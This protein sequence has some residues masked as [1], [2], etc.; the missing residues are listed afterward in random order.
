MYLKHLMKE[1]LAYYIP[2]V[3]TPIAWLIVR[4]AK[5]YPE[6]VREELLHPN[7]I[8]LF[9]VWQEFLKHW[10][11]GFRQPVFDALFKLVIVKYEQSPQYRNVLDWVFMMVTEWKPFDFTRQMLCWKGD[12]HV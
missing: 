10:D 3:D 12:R 1:N 8:R 11:F 6:P 4:Y 5:L 7:S 9:D 2:K